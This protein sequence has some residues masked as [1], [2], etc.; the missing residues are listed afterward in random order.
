MVELKTPL[1]EQ[2]EILVDKSNQEFDKGN[3]DESVK[4]LE[5]AWARLPEP[6]GIY[7]ESFHIVLYISETYLLIKNPDKAKGWADKIF[8]CD[9]ER[10]D[11]GQRE[12]LVG[13][14]SFEL[15]DFKAAK[16]YFSVANQKSQGRCFKSQDGKYLKFF[17]QKADKP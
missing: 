3:Y 1:K 9:L 11:S 4:I 8:Q 2:V 12:F 10:I 16:R 13:K 5:D 6:K 7:D 14:V 15:G 17:N